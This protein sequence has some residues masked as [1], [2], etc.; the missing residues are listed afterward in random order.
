MFDWVLNAPLRLLIINYHIPYLPAC[1]CYLHITLAARFQ[2]QTRNPLPYLLG[3]RIR[4]LRT[5]FW[6]LQIENTKKIL[7]INFFSFITNYFTF[8]AHLLTKRANKSHKLV[9]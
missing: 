6:K 8:F 4:K 1:L 7:A 2:L 5:V 9:V 3:V